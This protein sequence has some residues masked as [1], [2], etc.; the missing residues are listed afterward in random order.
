MTNYLPSSKIYS[1]LWNKYR[2]AILKLMIDSAE[3]PQQYKF[4]SHEFRNVNLKE[5]GGHSFTLKAFQGRA[6]NNIRASAVAKDLLYILQQS[7]KATE[8]LETSTFEFILDKQF[9]FHV[10]HSVKVEEQA[11]E[12]VAEIPAPE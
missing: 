8:L 1:Y 5:K 12:P 6:V 11:Q 3:G 2:P 4:S 10:T 7:K 9:V